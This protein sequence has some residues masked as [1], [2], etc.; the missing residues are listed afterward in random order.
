MYNIVYHFLDQFN[1][2]KYISF[3]SGLGF[4]IAFVFNLFLTNWFIKKHSVN[5]K[6][7]QKT[8]DYVPDSHKEKKV[9]AMGGVLIIIS[10]F[11][12]M[13]IVADF[14]NR[15][16]TI[17]LLVFIAFGLI[18]FYDDYSK[19]IKSKGVSAKKK[20][21]LQISSSAVIMIVLYFAYGN[22]YDGNL[23][24]FVIKNC[25]INI[26]ALYLLF[27]IFVIVGSSNAVNMTDGLDGLAAFP[28]IINLTCLGVFAYLIGNSSYSN[29]L[30]IHHIVD[31]SELVVLCSAV[32]GA[33][34]AF[35]WFNVKPAQ[36]FMGDTGSLS[37][38]GL[39][40]VIAVILKVEILLIILGSVFVI[41]TMSVIIQVFYF[42]RTKKRIFRMSPI[43]HHFELMGIPE[44][45]VVIRFW[46]VAIISGVITLA[47]LKIR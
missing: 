26:G 3:R 41:E 19:V 31:V 22:N 30:L 10:S 35:L 38:G 37:L 29:Y 27:N 11:L 13:L 14:S 20:F 44:N 18:G 7:L 32:V 23:I 12:S 46:I 15:Y 28:I 34:F 4:A 43:H 2:F 9:T 25:S 21:W 33:L 42:K 6:Y 1:L 45:K 16:I 17:S 24:I 5:S 40:G 36:I 39:I 8:R 47:T